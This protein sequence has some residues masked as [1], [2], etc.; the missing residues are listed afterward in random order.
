MLR[1]LIV[2][3][4]HDADLDGVFILTSECD[5]RISGAKGA[6]MLA[7]FAYGKKKKKEDSMVELDPIMVDVRMDEGSSVVKAKPAP[8]SEPPPMPPPSG[9]PPS[10]PASMVPS[11]PTSMVPAGAP[12]PV[13]AKFQKPKAPAASP[14]APVSPACGPPSTA[15]TVAAAAAKKAAARRE[16]SYSG[17]DDNQA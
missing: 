14:K 4:L 9:P 7:K 17:L 16:S 3:C 11:R 1:D 8:P 10:R 2:A 15:R 6:G 12:P 13:P 5:R